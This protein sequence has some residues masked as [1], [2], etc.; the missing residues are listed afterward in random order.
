MNSNVTLKPF[1][2]KVYNESVDLKYKKAPKY[3]E[4]EVKKNNTRA[5]IDIASKFDACKCV[6]SMAKLK[7]KK[8]IKKEKRS[9]QQRYTLKYKM[10]T[11]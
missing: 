11:N 4:R 10:S 2:F 8:R 3:R 1:S 5:C 6:F 9:E 7:F